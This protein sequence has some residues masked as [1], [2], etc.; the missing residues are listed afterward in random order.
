MSNWRISTKFLDTTSSVQTTLPIFG[1][2][3]IKA[4]KGPEDFYFFNKGETQKILDTYGY[5][6]STYPGIQDA[7]DFNLKTGLFISAPYKTGKHGGVFIT[8]EGTIP[9]VSGTSSKTIADYSAIACETSVGTGTGSAV[10]FTKVIPNFDYYVHQSIDIL[11]DGV[12]ITVTASNADPEVLT[13]SPDVGDGTYNRTTGTLSFTFDS[14]PALGAVITTSYEM[15]IDSIV[16]AT[17]YSHDQQA[18]DLKVKVEKD[19]TTP[20]NFFMN[21]YRYVP[22]EK[23]Y[24]EING[25][26]FYFSIDPL[27]KDGYGNNV[28]IETV[29]AEDEQVLFSSTVQEDTFDTFTNDT[30]SVALSGGLRGASIDGSDLA[31]AYSPLTDKTK[32]PTKII[33]DTT[34]E[35]NVATKFEQLRTGDLNRVRFMLPTAD[36]TPTE[37]IADPLTAANNTTDRGIYY[38]CLT[39]EIHKDLYQGRNF[40]CS[41]MGLI[42]GK[43]ADVL[44]LGPGGVPA[45]IDENGVGGQL[46]SSIVKFNKAATDSELQLLDQNRI[47]PV[48]NDPLY[49]PMIKSW[50]TRQTRISDYAYIGQSSL[51]D[52]IVDLI[53]TQVLPFQLGKAIDDFHMNLVKSKT[54]TILSSV[55][56]WLNDSYVLCDRTNNTAET[57]QQQK[58]ILTVG[59]QYTAYSNI[60]EFTFINTP[61]G[62]SVSEVVKK[63]A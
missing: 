25:S 31:T 48:V 51:A 40:N 54:E 6:S 35:A 56:R 13:T 58:F 7:I 50:R 45:W 46:G 11:V 2:T 30:T 39:W 61:Q 27:G 53:E 18:D 43:M 28:Y 41:N 37:I 10:T 21:V 14:A 8:K 36:L 63:Q 22:T 17:L 59:V 42:A 47:N 4:S 5:P 15:D 24:F 57:Q 38:Y 16:Y 62:V 12:S 1:A 32:Y 33:F 34:A 20:G 23:D 19:T 26:P 49:G 9:F 52:W 55:Q 60:I 3:A 29:F 44:L